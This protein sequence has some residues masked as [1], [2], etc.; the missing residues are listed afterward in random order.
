MSELVYLKYIC[1]FA[2]IAVTPGAVHATTHS[3]RRRY[4]TPGPYKR[5]LG[6]IQ[7]VANKL[8]CMLRAYLSAVI[9]Y[10]MINK[11]FPDFL[12]LQF[13]VLH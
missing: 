8:A 6:F 10:I 7:G 9:K 12:I 13:P 3:V 11:Q 4:T 1:F 2:K 5:L